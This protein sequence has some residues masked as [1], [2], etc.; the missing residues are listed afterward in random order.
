MPSART[1][2]ISNP[3]SGKAA[4][5]PNSVSYSCSNALRH[6]ETAP[7]VDL[8]GR[9]RHLEMVELTPVAHGERQLDPG[10]VGEPLPRQRV[11]GLSR[12][13][14]ECRLERG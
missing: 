12:H 4:P 3:A 13:V 10:F 2:T 7:G 14:S 11:A 5:L 6:A 9:K 8:L 1:E